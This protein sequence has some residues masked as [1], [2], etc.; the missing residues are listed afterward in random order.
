VK[1]GPGDMV[2]IPIGVQHGVQV[3][4]TDPVVMFE[5]V[6]VDFKVSRWVI[7]SDGLENVAKKLKSPGSRDPAQKTR[8]T[9]KPSDLSEDECT[10]IRNSL[11]DLKKC[12]IVVECCLFQ[13]DKFQILYY[14]DKDETTVRRHINESDV[15]LSDGDKLE[16][17]KL[18]APLKFRSTCL[19]A[20]DP[21]H[22]VDS[23]TFSIGAFVEVGQ[24]N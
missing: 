11:Q 15:E 5:S 14:S 17:V 2:E 3:L 6:I 24:V 23:S 9:Q 4:G 13:Q 1:L 20:G 19:A 16:L 12:D 21:I 8:Q 7:A 18:K 22:K 10:R